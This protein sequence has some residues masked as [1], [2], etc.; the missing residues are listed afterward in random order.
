MT[1][2]ENFWV[3]LK[4][5]LFDFL[6][7]AG[8][9]AIFA[10][11]ILVVG[12]FLVR[13]LLRWIKRFMRK[14]KVELSLQTF[15]ESLSIFFLYGILLFII[16]RYLGIEA[17]SFL[18]IFG[19]IGIAIGLALQGSLANF[20]GGI[21]ILM[22]KPFR[23]E[24]KVIIDGVFGVVD[25]INIL[26]TRIR[27][28]DGKIITMPNGKVSNNKVENRSILPDRRVQISLNFSFDEDFDELRE[29]IITAL[30]KHPK[31]V[32][33]KPVQFW[34]SEM[35]D[36]CM[37]TS[38]RCWA[39]TEEFWDVYWDQIEAV[40]KALDR[41]GIELAIPKRAIYQPDRQKQPVAD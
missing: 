37:K 5:E 15:I 24:D 28:W 40:K 34:L 18:A 30:A 16:G 22:F 6:F 26:Y 36:D 4:S 8:T 7:T 17:S 11:V 1:V 20:A 19:A 3:H 14:A 41:N 10:I 32:E 29:I 39:K 21:L 12:V 27:T 13:A 25:E 31:L 2:D 35:G 23:V 33:G 9:K 38:A